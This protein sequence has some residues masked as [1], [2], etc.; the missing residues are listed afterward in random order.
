[1]LLVVCWFWLIAVRCLLHIGDRCLP[2]VVC[3]LPVDCCLLFV[4]CRFAVR[5]VL[6][7]GWLVVG[8]WLSLAVLVVV[9]WLQFVDI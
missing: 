4:V 1:M 5:C 6:F 2:F 7:V 9:R 8:C 3:L